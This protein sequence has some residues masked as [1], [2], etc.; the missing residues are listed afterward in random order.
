M[1][2]QVPTPECLLSKQRGT[3]EKKEE[4]EAIKQEKNRQS[5]PDVPSDKLD[6]GAQMYM[7]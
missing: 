1:R 7:P 4:I 3:R 2:I 5:S 6:Y